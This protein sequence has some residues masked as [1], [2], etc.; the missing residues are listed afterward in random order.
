D[1]ECAVMTV[2]HTGVDVVIRA[3]AGAVT[4]D[5]DNA[6][7]KDG[8]EQFTVVGDTTAPVRFTIWGR[9]SKFDPGHYTVSVDAIRPA[10]DRDR[11]VYEARHLSSE[12]LRLREAGK[13][14]DAL[15]L[16]KRAM[17]R[18]E[19]ALDARDPLLGRLWWVLASMQRAKGDNRSAEQSLL[20]AI[21]I[22]QAALGREHPQTAQSI[23]HLGDVY[24]ETQDLAKAERF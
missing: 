19:P 5:I 10:T 12:A 21:E 17:T 18:G 7:G 1:G 8:R 15:D 22:D 2:E 14:D 11:A 4:A 16:A 9:Y 23:Q 13:L 24:N 6:T 20:R 3:T